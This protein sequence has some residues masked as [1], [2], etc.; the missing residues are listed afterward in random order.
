MKITTVWLSHG[1][2]H[3]RTRAH[4]LK[5]HDIDCDFRETEHGVNVYP[6]GGSEVMVS[7]P[8][9]NIAAIVYARPPEAQP[10]K[11]PAGA[12]L[13]RKVGKA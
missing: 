12:I 7:I 4:S 9:A 13:A 1:V 5:L 3:P 8:M 6:T 10:T 11:P 2:P